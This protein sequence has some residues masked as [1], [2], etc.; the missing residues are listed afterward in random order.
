MNDSTTHLHFLTCL[1]ALAPL[2]L[3]LKKL[4]LMDKKS[5]VIGALGSALLFVTFGAANSEA[6][7]PQSS[8]TT[9]IQYAS[10]VEHE[11]EFHLS[12]PSHNQPGMAFAINKRTGQ[13]RKYNSRTVSYNGRD[14]DGYHVCK[15]AE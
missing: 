5:L 3:S 8:T 11:W 13:V 14:Y 12:D 1:S 6:S 9:T 2:Y 10:P 15:P 7:A 4:N